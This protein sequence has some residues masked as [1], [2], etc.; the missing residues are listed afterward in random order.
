MTPNQINHLRSKVSN[1]GAQ[2]LMRPA[3]IVKPNPVTDD[4]IGEP[5]AVLALA[6]PCGTVPKSLP[7]WHV[8]RGKAV[9]NGSVFFSRHQHEGSPYLRPFVVEDRKS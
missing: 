1:S 3:L 9:E 5:L 2:G 4:S 6:V 8:G 7:F